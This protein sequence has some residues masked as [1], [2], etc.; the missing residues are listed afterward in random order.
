MDLNTDMV[1]FPPTKLQQTQIG[2]HHKRLSIV[3]IGYSRYWNASHSSYIVVPTTYKERLWRYMRDCAMISSM[4]E[5]KGGPSMEE[6]RAE[7][8][9]VLGSTLFV[10]SPRLSRLLQYLCT[11]YLEG[12]TEGQGVSDR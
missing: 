10:R 2:F 8:Q 6:A 1:I 4:F 11:K 5:V 7:L 12:A 3:F 9:S